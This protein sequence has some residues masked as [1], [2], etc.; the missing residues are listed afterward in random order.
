[1]TQP[2]R[3]ILGGKVRYAA[4]LLALALPLFSSV[5]QAQSCPPAASACTPGS[6]PTANIPFGMGILNVTL[7]TINNTTPGIQDGYKDY[8]CTL[9]AATLIIGADVPISIRTNTNADENVRVW[10][11]LNNDGTFSPT[12]ELLFS[13]NTKRT[14]TGTVRLPSGTIT[15]VRLRLRVAADYVNATLPS[16]CSTPQYSQ[17][18]DYAVIASASTQAPVT[19]FVADQTRTC[20]GTVQ[21]TDQSQNGP[22][23][24]RWDFG[25]GTTSL[26]QNP[27]YQYTTAGTFT[28]TLTTSNSVGSNTKT[29]ASYITYDNVVPVAATCAPAT[30]AF[31]CGYGITQ[32]TL[33]TLTQISANGQ[34][35]YEDFTCNG[36]VEV[37]VGN[38]YT[39]RLTTGP[40]NPQD[41]RVWLDLNND[42]TFGS[43]EQIFQAL[44]TSNPTGTFLVPATAVLNQPLRLRVVSDYV[45]SS[46][47]ACDG[48]QYGQAE[49]YTVTVRA[50]TSPPTADF[51][52]NYTAGSCQA[53]IQFT[54][55]S[56]NAPTGWLWTFGD[57]STSILQNP[58]HTY[59]NTGSYTVSLRATNAF[60][61]TTVTRANYVVVT[62]PCVQY[63]TALGD[64]AAFWITNVSLTTP[65]A[66]TFSN[67]SGANTNGYGNY[68]GQI[69]TLRQGQSSTLTV[70]ANA[71]FQRVTT[72]WVD[73]NRDGF[74]ATSELVSNQ[75]STN[76]ATIP[77][78]VPA[79][80]SV[81]GFTRMRIIARL[82]NNS[83]YACTG[84]TAQP[85]TEIEDY[86]V[87]VV[88]ATATQEAQ[89]LPALTVFPNPTTDG[90][91]HLRLA[92]ARAAD[93]YSV[94][95]ENMLGTCV[96]RGQLR[97]GTAADAGIDLSGLP[98]GL[99]VLRL[100]GS[101]GQSA[102]RRVLRD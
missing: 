29:R 89:S 10:A 95:V 82:N 64:N 63:C 72:V 40:G 33:G 60:G 7:G 74:F 18:E 46:F 99:Y 102:I 20:S 55:I 49:D 17:T 96:Y 66:T 11:D 4:G 83:A 8:S 31:C 44:N 34:A 100:R 92:N 76:P 54:D 65:Q 1:M 81:V 15:G 26:L 51:T 84:T 32:F 23:A 14:H 56:Q 19:D 75:I 41:T 21:F 39:L 43:G 30:A 48:V 79:L 3:T 69:M 88:P 50:N 37:T 91:L 53:A 42:G 68:A 27:S 38:R 86:S 36:K 101:H 90:H 94:A 45:G 77:V 73:W 5:A 16:P 57:G 71:N 62:V 67:A 28:V 58:S 25:D 22:T 93:T 13:S 35:G 61:T 9:G 2:L 6:A 59:A 98:R 12:S 47:T 78:P 97:L 85:N 70:T 52:S 87:Q 24:W 80:Q